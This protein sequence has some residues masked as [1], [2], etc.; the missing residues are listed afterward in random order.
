MPQVYSSQFKPKDAAQQS[1]RSVS[2]TKSDTTPLAYISQLT[3]MKSKAMNDG[4][5][6]I[7][8]DEF[9]S[10][11]RAVSEKYFPSAGDEWREWYTESSVWGHFCKHSSCEQV[12]QAS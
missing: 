9:Y 2:L 8:F 7:I 6:S 10:K 11:K 3:V 4:I 12:F 5:S 1:N